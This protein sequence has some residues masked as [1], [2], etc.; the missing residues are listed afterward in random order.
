MSTNKELLSTTKKIAKYIN[1]HNIE[2][3]NSIKNMVIIK[4]IIDNITAILLATKNNQVINNSDLLK[5]TQS[6]YSSIKL[7]S[8]SNAKPTKTLSIILSYY[9]NT[10]P[11]LKQLINGET[12]FKADNYKH[13]TTI[14]H[15]ENTMITNSEN[16]IVTNSDCQCDCCDGEHI[17]ESQYKPMLEEPVIQTEK[18]TGKYILDRANID[19]N[20]YDKLMTL[21]QDKQSIRKIENHLM[22][23]FDMLNLLKVA[24]VNL[25]KTSVE[26]VNNIAIFPSLLITDDAN[27][28]LYNKM[29]DLYINQYDNILR[30]HCGNIFDDFSDTHTI[31]VMLRNGKLLEL[32]II[33][34]LKINRKETELYKKVY[35]IIGTHQASIKFADYAVTNDDTIN[36]IRNNVAGM[37]KIYKALDYNQ[38]MIKKCIKTVESFI[39]SKFSQ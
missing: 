31:K 24:I 37:Q 13:S 26:Q 27:I 22:N 36:T 20:I 7:E 12:K 5:I 16:T 8:S 25:E 19:K 3:K 34:N 1:S 17:E 29:I 35:L 2:L 33:D 15:T 21:C 38:T 32:C 10:I 39:Q 14:Q 18:I 9:E 28:S 6:I 11:L 30:N 23:I 4:N